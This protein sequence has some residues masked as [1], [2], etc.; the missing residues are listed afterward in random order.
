MS[1]ATMHFGCD[2][3]P[4]SRMPKPI[5]D[6]LYN[7]VQS[8]C[9]S[10]VRFGQLDVD[11]I[12]S[13]RISCSMLY[14]HT[15]YD[16]TT[17]IPMYYVEMTPSTWVDTFHAQPRN[18]VSVKTYVYYDAE[19][20]RALARSSHGYTIVDTARLSKTTAL[21]GSPC[22]AYDFEF[23]VIDGQAMVL[24]EAIRYG[25]II[26]SISGKQEKSDSIYDVYMYERGI[27]Y[28]TLTAHAEL[29]FI[30]DVTGYRFPLSYKKELDGYKYADVPC[31]TNYICTCEICGRKTVNKHGDCVCNAC[32]ETHHAVV[33]PI[34]GEMTYSPSGYHDDCITKVCSYHTSHCTD[35]T[36]NV[37]S[38]SEFTFTVGFENELEFD[39]YREME[40]YI[41]ECRLTFGELF[42]FEHD[43][44][45][46][47][48]GV[49][50]IS[51]VFDIEYLKVCSI[52]EKYIAI[53]KKWHGHA[54]DNC[55][56]HLHIGR[57][58]FAES[59]DELN[60]VII[61]NRTDIYKALTRGT[62]RNNF[63]YCSRIIDVDDIEC[64]RSHGRS[65]TV[66]SETIEFR[67]FRA[68]T[69]AR[70]IYRILY[71]CRGIAQIAE[72]IT[73]DDA[74]RLTGDELINCLDESEEKDALRWL[75]DRR[76]N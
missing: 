22:L 14:I 3:T 32:K 15:E 16:A 9:Y 64:L 33:C 72:S 65:M 49:E 71:A 37:I 12:N 39:S 61:A 56:F 47:S 70:G 38:N 50:C 28:K 41:K 18:S 7:A 74:E 43:G 40:G 21:Y 44:S 13:N 31:D 53:V 11:I 45:L 63:D 29:T 67:H 26:D 8:D 30:S 60:T 73:T 46:A 25:V 76:Y 24:T 6:E 62:R 54:T 51:E 69:S 75:Y 2:A 42:H 1:V 57:K 20:D 68:Q 58:Y 27:F 66:D 59:R 34:C 52:V 4:S 48:C 35:R 5:F 55:G 10:V 23:P 36:F 17:D 19:G